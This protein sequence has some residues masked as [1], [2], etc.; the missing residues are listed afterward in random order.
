LR[1]Q[2]QDDCR[3]CCLD[4]WLLSCRPPTIPPSFS[5]RPPTE[6]DRLPASVRSTLTTTRA[7]PICTLK[8]T[9]VHFLGGLLLVIV[10][11]WLASRVAG[12]KAGVGA[13]AVT[14]VALMMLNSD[15][16]HHQHDRLDYDA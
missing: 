6:G 13:A 4:P 12:P 2:V 1:R 7:G 8:G 9:S 10:I 3:L 15:R 16:H 11:F 5:N 14:T